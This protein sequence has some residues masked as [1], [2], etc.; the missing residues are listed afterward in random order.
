MPAVAGGGDDGVEGALAG[1]AGG[2]TVVSGA[3]AEHVEHVGAVARVEDREAV[4]QPEARGEAAQD[5]RAGAVERPALDALTASVEEHRGARQHLAGGA[6]R[7][8]EQHDALGRDAA[9]DEEGDAV[10]ERPRLAGARARDDERR[11]GPGGRGGVLR[12]VERAGVVDAVDRRGRRVAREGERTGHE[13]RG[14]LER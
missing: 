6:A 4:G 8:G 1:E 12:R 14:G 7:E 5:A 9:L 10:D 3:G 2:C 11:P 13:G